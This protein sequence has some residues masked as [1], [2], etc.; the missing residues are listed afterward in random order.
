MGLELLESEFKDKKNIRTEDG[1]DGKNNKMS[2][3][4]VDDLCDVLSDVK[5]NA[6]TA[7]GILTDLLNYDRIEAGAMELDLSALSMWD[8]VESTVN[9]FKIQAV[10]RRINLNLTVDTSPV[11]D[12]TTAV[13]DVETGSAASIHPESLSV[14]GDDTRL[15]QVLRNLIS[16]ALVSGRNLFFSDKKYT[17]LIGSSA[18][19]L[20]QY[21]FSFAL[22][23]LVEV[24]PTGWVS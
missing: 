1:E 22:F 6:H 14:I 15:R 9:Q 23:D 18:F 21:P 5:E 11:N 17:G 4:Q 8:V 19:L 24:H 7:V 16:N 10:N 13:V 3:V 12:A 20:V 2:S